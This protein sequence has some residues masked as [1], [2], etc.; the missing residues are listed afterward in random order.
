MRDEW[1][2]ALGENYAEIQA[3]YI[4]SLGNLTLTRYNSEMGDKPFAEK[5]EVYKESA[6]HTLNKYVVQQS[7]WNE[8]TI[9][10]RTEI[11]VKL[12]L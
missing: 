4:H 9:L 5:L 2:Q 6:M 3:K 7:T 1:K 12:C 10:A 11:L 8:Q